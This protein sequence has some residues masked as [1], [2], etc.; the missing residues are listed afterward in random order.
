RAKLRMLSRVERERLE[1]GNWS[2]RESAG[3]MFREEWFPLVDA[4]PPEVVRRVRYWD[5]A[6]SKRRRSDFVAGVLLSLH[7]DGTYTVEGV[8]HEELRP[9]GTEDLRAR[10]AQGDGH[11]VDAHIEQEAVAAGELLIAQYQ[12]HVLRGYSVYGQR[13]R[14]EGSKTV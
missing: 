5:L 6:G 2:V 13:V 9:K 1:R 4:V 14:G 10:T 12:R 11:A 3:E 7:G 8:K